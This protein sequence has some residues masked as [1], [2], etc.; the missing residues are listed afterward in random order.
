MYFMSLPTGCSNLFAKKKFTVGPTVTHYGLSWIGRQSLLFGNPNINRLF[1]FR[2][3]CMYKLLPDPLTA[4]KLN[5]L[6][7]V[8]LL[9]PF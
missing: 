2:N 7:A 3:C 9:S 1:T 5:F 6:E 8:A 4:G